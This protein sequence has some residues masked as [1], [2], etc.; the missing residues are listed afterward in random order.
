MDD[1]E[2]NLGLLFPVGGGGCCCRCCYKYGKARLKITCSF[3]D[4]EI[5]YMNK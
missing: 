4:M 1:E 5:K 3:Y 2:W